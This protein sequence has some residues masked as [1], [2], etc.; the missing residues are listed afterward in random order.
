MTD[1]IH[2]HEDDWAMR[3]L[4][5]EEA[6]DQVVDEML[7]AYEAGERNRA[8]GGSGWT[9]LHVIKP[10]SIDYSD[11]RLSLAETAAALASVLPRVRRFNATLSSL[12]GSVER[13]PLGSYEEE[14]WCFGRSRDC[15][16]KLEPEGEL[17]R[18]IWFELRGTDPADAAA[19]RA[20]IEAVDRL[21]P[22]FLADYWLSFASPADG[23][24]LDAYF[25][26]HAAKEAEIA[27]MFEDRG[28]GAAP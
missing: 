12:I 25:A 1:A 10:P 4:Y 28:P 9:D 16:I 5:P 8:P 18:G 11:V 21:A 20:A 13:D 23:E 17:V 14:A 7:A 15:F 24:G 3:N 26:R 19:I 27:A 6:A 22:S 2:I